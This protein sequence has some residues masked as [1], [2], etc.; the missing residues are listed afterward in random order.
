MMIRE[1]IKKID[2]TLGML[3]AEIV[4]Y[5]ILLETAGIMLA[6][7]LFSFSVGLLCG[8]LAA[9]FMAVHMYCSI[10]R[11]LMLEEKAAVNCIRS[12]AV[13]RYIAVAG[14]FFLL[15]FTGMGNPASY[16]AGAFGLKAAAYLQPFFKNIYKKVTGTSEEIEVRR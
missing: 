9:E 4:L 15:Y 13:I 7:D 8:C 5:G 11:M 6:E 12:S 2:E 10:N 16:V 1:R 3:M 14:G